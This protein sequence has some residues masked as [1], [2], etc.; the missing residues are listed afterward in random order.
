VKD[1][2]VVKFATVAASLERSFDPYVVFNNNSFLSDPCPI[3]PPLQV[4]F[5]QCR[6]FE[7]MN[8]VIKRCC[9]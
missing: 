6:L 8:V 2:P 3:G 9:V 1:D 5:I 4:L 7:S